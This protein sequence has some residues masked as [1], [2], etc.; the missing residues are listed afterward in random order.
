MNKIYII[1]DVHCRSFYKPILQIKDKPIIFLGDYL[2]PYSHE[3]TSDEDGIANLEE[4]I[5][6]ARCNNNVTLLSGNH[7]L[8]YIWSFHGIERTSHKYYNDLHN[9]YRNNIDLF[10]PCC[11]VQ[12][13]LFTHAGICKGFVTSV[14]RVFEHE[15]SNFRLNKDNLIDWINN[16]WENELKFEKCTQHFPYFTLRSM[17]FAI[18]YARW[19][20]APYGGPFWCDFNDEYTDPN[21]F[22][23]YQVFGHTQSIKTGI[24]RDK[25]NG[26]CLDSR[27]IFEYNLDTHEVKFSEINEEETQ[28]KFRKGI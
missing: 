8:S 27:A 24:I 26:I 14:N 12:D 23:L 16:E 4:I 19:G 13:S 28:N 7:D 6:F 15:E 3:G 17:I 20:D 10:K 25:G 2:D 21:N 9:I 1:P 5:D 18:G 11:Q 22:N